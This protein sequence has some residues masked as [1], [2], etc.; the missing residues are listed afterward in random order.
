MTDFN[1]WDFAITFDFLK[2]WLAWR[3]SS[4]GNLIAWNKSTRTMDNI[5]ASNI[6]QADIQNTVILLMVPPEYPSKSRQIC[7]KLGGTLFYSELNDS[8][9]QALLYKLQ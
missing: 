4:Q 9:T 1:M 8:I 3:N 5:T 6:S 2:N 7:R